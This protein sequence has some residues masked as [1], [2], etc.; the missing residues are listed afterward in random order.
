MKKIFLFIAMA[1]ML[2][3]CFNGNNYVGE[4]T[5]SVEYQDGVQL[6]YRRFKFQGHTYIEFTRIATWSYDN[7]TGYVHDPDC[8]CMQNKKQ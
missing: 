8:P 4:K 7:V 2:T 3:S 5:D 1:L 6:Q